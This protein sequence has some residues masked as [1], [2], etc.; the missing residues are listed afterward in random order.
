MASHAGRPGRE[1]LLI[2]HGE[3]KEEGYKISI[4][5]LCRWFGV[6]RST[7]YHQ[8]KKVK[9]KEESKEDKALE[10]EM[11]TIIDDNP[12]YGVRRI[13]AI[14]TFTIGMHVN[15]KRVY[16]LY[17]KN[18]WQMRFKAK[19]G[20]PRIKAWPSR[21]ATP[22]HRWAID[23][24]H[25]FCGK[26]GWCHLTAIIDCCTREIVGWRFSKRGIAKVAAAALEDAFLARKLN[27]EARRQLTLR[28]DN[29]LVFGAKAFVKVVRDYEIDQE[30]ITP[31]SPQQNGMIERFFRSLK[32]ESI[33]QHR[34]KDLDE[35]F[36]VV[37]NWLDHYNQKRLHSALGYQTP[38][39]YAAKLAA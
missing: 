31:Y 16:R 7:F 34:F 38:L 26:D 23:T 12:T 39:A 24:T 25:I 18:Q 1:T 29:G 6:P 8:P 33:W 3:L 10:C 21:A 35:A 27:P 11:K 37:A 20:R 30:Y 36:I 17:R 15:W 28:S 32:E 14:L 5:K 13:W 9:Q 2:L 19:G 22:N 4:R